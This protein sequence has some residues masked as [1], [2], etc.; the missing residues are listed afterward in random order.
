[1]KPGTESSEMED[2]VWD[3]VAMFVDV[4]ILIVEA[5]TPDLSLK[6]RIEGPHCPHPHGGQGV[7]VKDLHRCDLHREQCRRAD[8]IRTLITGLSRNHIPLNLDVLLL[9]GCD[10]GQ[11]EACTVEGS[12]VGSND[13][14]ILLERWEV[15]LQQKRSD[16]QDPLRVTGQFLLQA[17]RSYLHFSQLSSWL[18]SLQGCLPL[19][20]VYR[21]YSPG[22]SEVHGFTSPAERHSF[23]V[24]DLGAELLRVCVA[25][26]PRL[27]QIPTLLCQDNKN[28]GHRKKH[29]PD[30]YDP[31]DG[32]KVKQSPD[33]C[34]KSK[35]KDE[36]HIYK[37]GAEAF[38]PEGMWS[39]KTEELRRTSP[40]LFQDQ[41]TSS[42]EDHQRTSLKRQDQELGAIPK[43]EKLGLQDSGGTRYC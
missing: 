43:K 3:P 10:H 19:Q 17:L 27:A 2:Y 8:Q 25:S 30:P 7:K 32:S 11:R 26:L 34:D 29:S 21:L 40:E 41:R 4:G 28:R 22:E 18:I 23:P 42:T 37:S 13:D 38:V 36:A 5:R 20:V 14:L 31:Y 35:V 39:K 15:S 1:M 33:L 16:R 6:G 12:S 9:P 24:A